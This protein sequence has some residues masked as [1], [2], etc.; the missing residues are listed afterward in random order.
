MPG[1]LQKALRAAVLAG[2]LLSGGAAAAQDRVTLTWW[3]YYPNPTQVA[4]LEALFAEYTA[5]HPNVTF[6]RT[7]VPIS[8]YT[9]NVMLAAASNQLPDLLVI[10]NPNHSAVAATGALLD[11]TEQVR[12]AGFEE[13]YLEGP[14]SSAKYRDRF[15]GLPLESTN[16]AV[17]YNAKMLREKGIEPPT[18]WD[19]YLDAAR[20]LT[21]PNVYGHGALFPPTE[22]GAYQFLP[23]LWSAGGDLDRLDGPEALRALEYLKTFFDEKLIPSDAIV[24]RSHNDLR[25]RFVAGNIAMMVNM[26]FQIPILRE[27]AQKSGLEWGV[28][29]LPADKERTSILGGVNVAASARSPHGDVAWDFIRFVAESPTYRQGLIDSYQLPPRKDY[30]ADPAWQPSQE[31]KV[32]IDNMEVARARAYGPAYPQVSDIL[33]GMLQSVFTGTAEPKAALAAAAER[34][35]PLL[36][37]N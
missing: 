19:E 25:T 34:I 26:P 21:G 36:P 18:T 35:R 33:T 8:D 31:M 27:E 22:T 20:K 16:L 24:M 12:E 37:A 7:Y 32:F 3:D 11:V 23:F 5:Q 10:D 14:M 1:Y 17:F 13:Q 6:E 28:V 4:V 2:A 15:Y 9:K 29:P 30:L